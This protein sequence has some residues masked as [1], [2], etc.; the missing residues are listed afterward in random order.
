MKNLACVLSFIML[1][2]LLTGIGAEAWADNGKIPITTA[3][4]EARALFLQGRDLQDKF[5]FPESRTFFEQATALDSNFALAYRDLANSQTSTKQY[6]DCLA[7]AVSLVDKASECERLWILADEAAAQTDLA[8]QREYLGRLVKSCAGDERAHNALAVYYWAR[9]YY[10]SSA[11]E[12]VRATELAPAF[13]TSWNM[14]G[15]ARRNL[16]DFRGAEQAFLKYIELNPQDA[17]PYDSYAELLLKEGRYDDA[18]I[19]YREA[20]RVDTTFNISRF[21]MAAPLLYAGKHAEALQELQQ[22]LNKARSD[23]DRQTANFGIAVVYLDQG[24]YDEALAALNANG[25]LSAKINDAAQ[26]SQNAFNIGTLQLE[27]GRND[28]A[29]ASF[30]RSVQ[31]IQGSSLAPTLKAFIERN[32]GYG[33]ARAALQKRDIVR[34]KTLAETFANS[35]KAAG[36]VDEVLTVHELNGI[37]AL[38]EKQYGKAVD[39]LKQAS[40]LDAGNLYRLALAYEGLGDRAKAKENMSAAVHIN[41]LLNLNDVAVRQKAMALAAEWSKK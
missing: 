29:L 34:A 24:K 10:D 20:L 33:E 30:Q 22:M 12:L 36:N 14:L 5:K 13:L 38:D 27:F 18:V 9:Q 4:A 31:I 11:A 15:Y 19:R 7:K 26:M 32:A 41:S 28:D 37:I 17:N 39:E 6:L 16:N 2:L 1:A 23:G 8:K 35:V 25:V 40:L 21:N 3:S